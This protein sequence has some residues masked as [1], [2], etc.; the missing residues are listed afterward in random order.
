V[1]QYVHQQS[2]FGEIMIKLVYCLRKRAD[3]TPEKFYSYWLKQHGP[4]VAGVAA[5]LR[6]MKYVQSHTCAPELNQL[7]L[8]SRGLAPAYDGITE[9]WWETE[10]TLKA[11]MMTKEGGDAIQ[12]LLEDESTFIDFAQSRVFMTTEHGIFDHTPHAP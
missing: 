8:E 7:L 9:L 3:V 11:A 4:K 5:T 1:G 2:A 6:A 12:M 10:D